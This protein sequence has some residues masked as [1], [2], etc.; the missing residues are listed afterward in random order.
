MTI[1]R[2]ALAGHDHACPAGG[3]H[4]P[5]RTAPTRRRP[6]ICFVAPDAWPVLSGDSRLEVIG[7]AEVQQ[8]IIARLLA[9][10]GYPVSMICQDFGQP[11]RVVVDG[12]TVIKTFRQEAGIPVV[13]FIHPRLTSI[14]R[15]MH[16][17]NADIYYQRSASMLTAVIAAY[18]RRH[19][20][21]SIYAGASDSDFVPGQQLIQFRRDRWLFER[22]LARVD[23]VIVQNTTQQRDCLRHYGR[24]SR[25]IP[26][27]YQLPADSRKQP[28]DYILWVSRMH[29]RKRP[30]LL[31]EIA[32]R[33]PHRRFVMIGGASGN[34][35]PYSTYFETIRAAAANLPNVDFLGFLPLAETEKHFDGARLLVST[36][37]VE[38][39][40]NV[41]L[42]AW[43][44]GVPTL[45]L[46]DPGAR[47]AGQPVC[48]A[49]DDTE[50]LAQGIERLCADAV[51]HARTADHVRAYFKLTHSSAGTLVRYERLLEQLS[52]QD[53]Q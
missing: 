11:G 33:L 13:R 8:C 24:R 7:G 32:R 4:A 50:A 40:P 15:A 20:K 12:I 49:F 34:H 47:L 17:A 22:G 16:A 27:V 21:H 29:E 18:C 14:W 1:A 3:C 5:T 42:Q 41:Y 39:M 23:T 19:G 44:R 36:S 6:H 10:A 35:P 9:R 25:L 37:Q 48:Q 31:L 46:F 38:G 45:G 28:D 52:D 53:M 26:S 43:A 30:E 51:L 2:A